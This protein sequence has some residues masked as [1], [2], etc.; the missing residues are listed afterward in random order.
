MKTNQFSS[1]QIITILAH[2]ERGDQTIGTICRE[3]GL[4][5][6]TSY[7]WRKEFAGITGSEAQRLRALAKE[8]TRLRRLLA[9]RD[10]EVDALTGVLAKKS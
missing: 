3:H 4:T 6:T 5:E 1:E 9:A 8:N 7:R 2:A 10:L